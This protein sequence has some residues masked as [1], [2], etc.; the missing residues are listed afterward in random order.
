MQYWLYIGINYKKKWLFDVT[1][2][3]SKQK[4]HQQ[5]SNQQ[6]I[7]KY[8]MPFKFRLPSKS[9]IFFQQYIHLHQI[10]IPIL[11][12]LELIE[13]INK[14]GIPK[15]IIRH[16]KQDLQLGQS[17]SESL[18]KHPR[19]FD[20]FSIA[21][22]EC[23]EQSG[24]KLRPL[25]V[26]LNKQEDLKQFKKNLQHQL[27]Y[28]GFVLGFSACFLI[29][30]VQ[31]LIP[32]YQHFFS[33]FNASLPYPMLLMQQ[34]IFYGFSLIIVVLLIALRHKLPFYN[35]IENLLLWYTWAQLLS[36]CIASGLSLQQSLEIIAQHFPNSAFKS[37]VHQMIQ[38]V[39]MGH[40]IQY[41]LQYKKNI[42]SVVH[43]YL[44][45]IQW[46][47][48]CKELFQQCADLLEKQL[49][50]SLKTI[51]KFLQPLI[52]SFVTLICGWFM[53]LIYLPLL[54]MGK[55]IQ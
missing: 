39:R 5:L 42:P 22:I 26:W 18:K 23:A 53:F 16:L 37:L 36:I 3:D 45:L 9:V 6:I 38:D 32:Q 25:E 35:K 27:I 10:G 21:L 43:Y 11:S 24:S 48:S 51:E 17:F 44:C 47:G 55:I 28:P 19:Y 2:C 31:H 49:Q 20:T 7:V 34:P 12:C 41:R 40:S 8:A 15:F 4:L 1:L 14:P 50:Q 13:S 30:F 46:N 29:F 52:L 33:N 54:E